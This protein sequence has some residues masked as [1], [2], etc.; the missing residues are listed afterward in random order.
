[1]GRKPGFTDEQ[2]FVWL[3]G[4]LALAPGV[5]VQQVSKGTGVSVGSIYHRYGSMEGLLAEAWLWAQN[6]F[7]DHLEQQI[8]A[9]GLQGGLRTAVEVLRFGTLDRA[10]AT[11]L[12]IVPERYLV[13]AVDDAAVTERVS[14]ARARQGLALEQMSKRLNLDTDTVELAVFRLPW[15]LI[16]KYLPDEEIPAQAEVY[17]RKAARMILTHQTQAQVDAEV[18]A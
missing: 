3:S 4:H 11:L 16:A 13:R 10:A 18:D 17:V 9:E 15:A 5:T 1:M 2:V 14:T 12:F 7:C 8:L 6:R